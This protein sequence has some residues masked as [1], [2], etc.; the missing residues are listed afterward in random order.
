MFARL[1]PRSAALR[2][3]THPHV[4]ASGVR[5]RGVAHIFERGR[6]PVVVDLGL[7][8]VALLEVALADLEAGAARRF[9]FPLA[10]GP[11]LI[12]GLRGLIL[13]REPLT[14]HRIRPT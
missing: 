14:G 8:D 13:R 6:A 4:P 11:L 1:L 3:L 2:L 10:L 12:A 5:P 9:I 7:Y